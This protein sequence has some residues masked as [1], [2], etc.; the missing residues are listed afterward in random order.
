MLCDAISLRYIREFQP[1]SSS[2]SCRGSAAA[3]NGDSAVAAGALMYDSTA[4]RADGRPADLGTYID[5][6]VETLVVNSTGNQQQIKVSVL[7]RSVQHV[8]ANLPIKFLFQ[9]PST[10][11]SAAP[12]K[13]ELP[14]LP[15]SY[16]QIN[17]LEN[18]HR[19]LK[20]QS[21]PDTP[22]KCDQDEAA[23]T[24]M[25]SVPLTREVLQAHTR[26]WEEQYR[27][28]WH[29]RLKRMSAEVLPGAPAY[30]HMRP[31]SSCTPPAHWSASKREEFYRSLAPNP[32]PP[33]GMNF[34]VG[35]KSSYLLFRTTFSQ[36]QITTIPLPPLEEKSTPPTSTTDRSSAFT[37][38]Q[39]KAIPVRDLP[40]PIAL[41]IQDHPSVIH[42]PSEPLVVPR[43]Q[44]AYGAEP[45]AL[46]NH[47][48]A[49]HLLPESA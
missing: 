42:T 20:S 22:N 47:S 23:S 29:R 30:K 21:R 31:A 33:P 9:C 16:N 25:A 40:A 48:A 11:V 4:V 19:L 43:L 26:R 37:A 27:D 34:Q 24:A 15:L 18:V 5:R 44:W 39:P 32:P 38:V 49:L 35:R 6:L 12:V 8:Q 13:E 41:S 7:D 1:I 28:T 45:L 10:S 3:S 14:D 2:S 17:C 36:F 46:K